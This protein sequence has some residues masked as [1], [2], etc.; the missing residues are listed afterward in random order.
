MIWHII[1]LLLGHYLEQMRC[2]K[3]EIYIVLWRMV[4]I[5]IL[6]NKIERQTVVYAL[7]LNTNVFIL[8]TF[9]LWFYLFG[10]ESSC[11][12]I[13][14][15]LA[16]TVFLK[17]FTWKKDWK[18]LQRWSWLNFTKKKLISLLC[19]RIWPKMVH[20][21]EGIT[22]ICIKILRQYAWFLVT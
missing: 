22:L 16:L 21:V 8:V 1:S 9:A 10:G 20:V 15:S 19:L 7:S 13:R 6:S 14:L 18:G 12:K 5:S 4:T 17:S 2:F 3:T 11:K